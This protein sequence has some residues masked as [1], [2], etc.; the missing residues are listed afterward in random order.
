M[1]VMIVA[2]PKKIVCF[3]EEYFLSGLRTTDI[4]QLVVGSLLKIG[5]NQANSSSNAFASFRSSVSKP[6]W[7]SLRLI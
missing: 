4:R 7:R 6:S 2:P 5:L 1:A 3:A